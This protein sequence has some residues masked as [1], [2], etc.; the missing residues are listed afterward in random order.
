MMKTPYDYDVIVIGAGIAGMVSAVTATGLGK[1]VAVIEKSKVGGNCTNT[2]C[3]PSKTLIRLG[4][5]AADL[6]RLRHSG[7]LAGPVCGPDGEAMLAHIRGVVEKAHAKDAPETFAAIGITMISGAASFVDPHTVRIGDQT[8][9]AKKFIIASGTTPLIPA[10]DGLAGIDFLTNETLY[11]LK[12][13]PAS[14]MILGGGVDGLEYASAFG[15]LGVQ[16]TIVEAATRLL[17]S[18][19][20]E[21]VR[22]LRRTLE[23]DGIRILSGAKAIH[24]AD[25]GGLVRLTLRRADGGEEDITAERLLVAVGRKP[26][27]DG[28]DLVKAGVHYST[29]GVLTDQKLCTSCPHI[30]ACGDIA[31]PYQLAATAEAQ[32]IVAATNAS[33]PVKRRVDYQNL[34]SVIFTL[35]A[36]AY[37][38]LSERQAEEKYRDKLR[39]YR[40]DYTDMRRALIDGKNTGMAKFLC[41]GKGRLVGAHILG[42]NAE[43]VI[44]EVQVIMA[45]QKPLHQLGS[46]THAYPT[47]AQALVGRACQLAFL[48]RM[49]GSVFVRL[50]LWLLPG[51]KNR[52]SVAR[53][54][55]AEAPGG[56]SAAGLVPH[57]VIRDAIAERNAASMISRGGTG[58][59]IQA[60]RIRANLI[61]LD[62]SGSLDAA[63][64]NL[65]DVQFNEA[66]ASST[67]LLL[68]MSGV[69][70][71]DPEGAGVLVA[72]A[73]RM[74]R[75][76]I[77]MAAC[78]L[79]DAIRDVFH[80][81]RLDE[82]M[83]LFG[84]ISDA[85]QGAD[86]R[87]SSAAAIPPAERFKGSALSGWTRSVDRL[88]LKDIPASAMN[89]N[90]QGRKTTSPVTGFGPLWD[91]RYRMR[92]KSITA[93]P[94]EIIAIWKSE[95]SDFW[96]PGNRFYPSGNKPVEPGTAAVLNLSLPGGLVLATGLMVIYADETSFSFITIEGHILGGWINF[97][98]FKDAA[99]TI[100][101]V[102]PLFRA[103]DPLM[104]AGFRMG[105]ALQEDKF[106]HATLERLAR[107]LDVTGDLSQEDILIDPDPNWKAAANLLDSA[108]IRSSLYMPW[109]WLKK[110]GAGG[111]KDKG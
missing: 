38:G 13:W 71:I 27:L 33:L 18:A 4:H 29:R 35:P 47:Y 90:V 44:H 95:F 57:Q 76:K 62:I 8:L 111:R 10:I 63:C 5:L 1:R 59:D 87:S 78:C 102:N 58:C 20:Q 24:I 39:T 55:L 53:D 19:D 92:I 23:K 106:W 93:R 74:N 61:I 26:D 28:L 31:G 109:Y 107:R 86:F 25:S 64:R 45:L 70:H 52:L 51:V 79:T 36:Y 69:D 16:T 43:E 80:L 97:S 41:D 50:A 89:I 103:G 54:R 96:P 32:A 21:I 3:I 82:A 2:T 100:I 48:D 75:K 91:K 46:L 60:R 77:S 101:Q 11:D 108:A 72:G 105:A 30:Y 42:E 110:T 84:D 34:V 67:P 94:E 37:I 65:L 88:S 9:R 7:I 73:A 85:L 40:F 22:Y 6:K 99:D 15:R 56:L 17:P 66:L 98:C 83:V 12:K 104:D 68:N 81:T 49:A 14:L